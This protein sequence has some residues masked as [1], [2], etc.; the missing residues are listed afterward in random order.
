MR[1]ILSDSNKF[2]DIFAG[3][4]K[5]LNFLDHLDLQKALKLSTFLADIVS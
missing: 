5:Q 2:T 3:K 1:N 4:K